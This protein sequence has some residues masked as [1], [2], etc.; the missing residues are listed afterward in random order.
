MRLRH[1][2][3]AGMLAL[4]LLAAS[5]R[6]ADAQAACG[7]N[8]R[9]DVAPFTCT[10]TRVIDGIDVTVTLNL[11][12]TGRAVVDY[13]LAPVPQADVPIAVHSYTNISSDPQ[14]VVE[15]V[16]PAGQTAGQLVVPRVECGQ[17]DMKAVF[18]APGD[19]A[20]L[21]AGPVVTW[22]DICQT[23]PTTVAPT[24]VSPTTAS[25]ASVGPTIP[26]TGAG[27]VVPWAWSLPVLGVA[28]VLVL[29]SRGRRRAPG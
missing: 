10:V 4:G 17:L 27:G 2:V 21:V 11:D 24:T 19:T 26:A 9:I 8:N 1:V 25:P 5:G 18:T 3:V 12:T 7:G 15:G 22:G 29:V 28:A 14:H 13:V 16:V 20:G 6:V 23:A